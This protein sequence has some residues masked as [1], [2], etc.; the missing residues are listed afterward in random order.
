MRYNVKAVSTVKAAFKGRVFRKGVMHKKSSAGMAFIFITL[1]IDVLGF[2]L[3]IPVLPNLVTSLSQGG[4]SVNLYGLLLASYG[5]M[6]FLFA[7]VLGSLSDHFGRRPVLLVS[8]FFTAIN[9]VIMAHAPTVGWLFVGRILA[10]ITGASYATATAYIADVSPPEKRAQNF[11]VISAAF[12]VGLVLGPMA[13]GYLGDHGLRWPFWAAAGLSLLNWLYGMFVLPESLAPEHRRAF[14]LKTANP[15]GAFGIIAR[16]RWVLILVGCAGL[17]A[18]ALQALQSTWVLYTTSRFQWS[19]SDNGLS[20][21]LIGIAIV[22]MQIGGTRVLI[23]KVGEKGAIIWG[24]LF[25][26]IGFVGFALAPTSGSLIAMA[27]IWSLSFVA[28][29]ATQSLISRQYGPDEQGG[30]QG[31]MTGLQSLTQVVG[32]VLATTVYGYFTSVAAPVQAPGSAFLL[33]ALLIAVSA[34][35]AAVAFRPHPAPAATEM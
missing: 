31:A 1:L 12:G 29:P 33:G 26:F 6:Q 35:L 9:Y 22:V 5:L 11:G 4:P 34:V 30:I 27:L 28:G 14:K 24:L 17:Q 10:G 23:P 7:P 20:F 18:L 25:N 19:K 3:I 13:G 2:G 32:P 8:L 21:A 16:H 15:L